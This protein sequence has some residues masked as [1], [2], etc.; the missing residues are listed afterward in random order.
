MTTS[1]SP[2]R[3]GR[4]EALRPHADDERRVE[5][6][7]HDR[8]AHRLCRRPGAAD[9]GDGEAAVAVDLE[10]VV[11]RAVGG[12]RGA[13]RPAGF[14]RE[15]TTKC[16]RAPR[17]RRVDAEPGQGHHCPTPEGAFYVYPSCAGTIG[18]TAPSGKVIETDE[19]FATELLE[20]EGVAVVQGAAFG[21]ARLPHLL[22][23][24]ERGP[25]R[26][27]QAHPALLRN[28]KR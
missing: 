20:A 4:A 12:G 27:L 17:S 19:D 13:E 16:S 7:L 28:L 21:L 18:K 26:R 1:S 5:G 22:R 8:L 23:D 6:L 24:V 3:A 11:D 25:G 2:R 9:Q 10:P 14:H 15:A